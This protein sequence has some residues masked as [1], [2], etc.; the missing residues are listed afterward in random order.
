M[1]GA[2][3][4]ETAIAGETTTSVSRPVVR[5]MPLPEDSLPAK[6]A[7]PIPPSARP[8]Y[9]S[10]PYGIDPIPPVHE[11][12]EPIDTQAY[13]PAPVQEPVPPVETTPTDMAPVV[14]P[15]PAPAPVEPKIFMA[16]APPAVTALEND[17]ETDLKAGSYEEA[18]ASL[19]RAIRIQPKN[20]ELWHVL[21]DVRLRQQQPGLAEDL[22]KKSNLL[23]KDNLELV[24][25]N[26][27]IIAETRTLK[28][29]YAGASEAMDKA[30]P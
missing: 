24:R 15:P 23:A 6:S 28:G 26:W 11:A 19:E 2:T 20:A 7:P 22:A 29:D 25:S 3:R 27:K 5:P 1:R 21:A 30:R 18:A 13:Q 10:S 14:E 9:S 8:S 4:P 17:I 16:N 12:P